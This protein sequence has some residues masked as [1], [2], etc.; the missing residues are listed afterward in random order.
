MATTTVEDV[1]AL[2]RLEY[3]ELPDLALTFWQAQRLWNLPDDICERALLSL[4]CDQVLVVTSTGFFIRKPT[5]PVRVD[6]F[7]AL[8]ESA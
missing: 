8:I 2:I 4:V 6:A 5:A 7:G 3:Y 1:K